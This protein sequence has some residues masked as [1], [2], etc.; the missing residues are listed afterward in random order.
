MPWSNQGGGGG[1]WGFR[2]QRDLGDPGRN[3]L[4]VDPSRSRR[5]PAPEQ[6]KLKTVLPGGGFGGR[7]LALL[8]LV[9]LVLWGASGFYRVQPGELGV[10]LRFGKYVRTA[11]P[12]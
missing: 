2:V 4:G 5:P 1:P 11:R 7:G 9:A 3:R 8:A 6:D 10:V 12:V